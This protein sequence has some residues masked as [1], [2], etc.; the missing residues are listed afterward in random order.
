MGSQHVAVAVEFHVHDPAAVAASH[1][2]SAVGTPSAK[3]DKV[4]GKCSVC[5]ACCTVAFLPT[6]VM[7]FT[8]PAPDRALAVVELITRVGFFTDGPDR[9]PR[10]FL[11]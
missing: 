10:L 3:H 1:E 7:A 6:A 2:G 11:T 9:P 5:A 8:A 4:M